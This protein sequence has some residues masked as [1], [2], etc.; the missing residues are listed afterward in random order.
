MPSEA[1]AD[2]PPA[3]PAAAADVRLHPLTLGFATIDAARRMILPALGGGLA[4]GGG[5]AQRIAT[6]ML[7]F[8]TIP[9]LLGAV[10]KY[11]FFRYGLVGDELVL[12]SGV[13]SRRHRVIPLARVQN[14]EVR[15]GMLQRALGVA[16]VRVETAGVAAEAEAVLSVLSAARAQSLREELLARRRAAGDARAAGRADPGEVERAEPA[17]AAPAVRLASR[18]TLDLVVAGATANEAGVIAAAAFGLLQFVDRVPLPW[19]QRLNPAALLEGRTAAAVATLVVGVVLLFVL[20]GWVISIVGSVV[21]YH[22]FTLGR[23]ET[24]LRKRYGLLTVHETSV[25]LHRVQALRVEESLLRRPFGL[26]TLMIETAGGRPGSRGGAEAFVPIARRHEVPGLVRGIFGDVD[27][28]ALAFHRV[29]PRSRLRAMRRYLGVLALAWL[30]LAM[31]AAAT[32]DWTRALWPVLALPLPFLLAAWQYRN[33]GYALAPGYVVA[34]SGVL[35]RVTWIVPD[36][37][38]QTL[39]LTATPFQ[40]RLRLTSLVV[41]TAASGRQAVVMDLGA[42]VGGVL[43]DRLAERMA[44]AAGTT[45]AAGGPPPIAPPDSAPPTA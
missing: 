2:A 13:L 40:R 43:L 20:V 4:A 17:E 12:R 18:G 36:R 16:E 5:Q 24:E 21:R 44:A 38:L 10:G 35:N 39:H 1:P 42:G 30:P 37:K 14:V 32:G 27:V 31:W 22:G 8:L 23:T 25:P 6:W 19:L 15:Q 45:A 11:L 28:G 34:R 33:R 9:A 41:D 26:A 29:H 3:A 7:V